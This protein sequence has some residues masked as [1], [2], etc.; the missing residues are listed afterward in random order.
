LDANLIGTYHGLITPSQVA[1]LTPSVNVGARIELTTTSVGSITGQILEGTT[2][3]SLKG[4]LQASVA[5]PD[6]PVAILNLI[7]PKTKRQVTLN[8]TLD[9]TSNTLAGA[10]YLTSSP[11]ATTPIE[12][13]RNT[14]S[15][16]NSASDYAALH[17]FAIENV[18]TVQPSPDGFGFGNF[19]PAAGT[20]LLTIK[21]N[22]ADGSP[23]VCSTFVG[24]AG[25]VLFYQPLYANT[26]SCVG[27][28]D[29]T[30][31]SPAPASNTLLGHLS[32]FKPASTSTSALVYRAGFAPLALDVVGSTYPA[33]G[34]GERVLGLPAAT[35]PATNAKM[36]FTL[37][38]LDTAVPTSQEFEQL[39]N[40]TNPSAIGFTNVASFTTNTNNV[41]LRTLTPT[42]GVFSGD[43]TLQGTSAALNRKASF[44]GQIVR[45]IDTTTT[46]QGYG[47]FLLPTL[48]STGQTV[49]TSPKL[50]G[51]V[52]MRAP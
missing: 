37:G 31:G 13:W 23:V 51:R 32:W 8:V 49:A 25:Q 1:Y 16:G 50:S 33:P 46:M 3:V 44:S 7:G 12:G 5:D 10:L 21:G 6:H 26:G 45:I 48:P 18:S 40:I 11:A 52:L 19:A 24:P 27:R 22:L 20:G 42:D 34:A 4:Q 36:V 9:K 47:Y 38:G 39:F 29:I 35:A 30:P 17:T 28:L 43:F 2:K 15:G 14:W 41:T